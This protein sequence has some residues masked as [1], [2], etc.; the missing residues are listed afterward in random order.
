MAKEEKFQLSKHESNISIIFL[1][2]Q[3]SKIKWERPIK[4]AFKFVISRS[5]AWIRKKINQIMSSLFLFIFSSK[6]IPCNQ[7]IFSKHRS[8][9]LKDELDIIRFYVELDFFSLT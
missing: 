8:E 3:T 5:E 1:F 2:L 4:K 7:F 6:F 9:S